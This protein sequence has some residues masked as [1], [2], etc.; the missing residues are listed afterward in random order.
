MK[1]LLIYIF[2]LI[3]LNVFSQGE[4][5]AVTIAEDYPL[6][7]NCTEKVEEFINKRIRN[8]SLPPSDT[9][10][11]VNYHL[12]ALGTVE[13]VSVYG[14]DNQEFVSIITEATKNLT[15]W[16]PAQTRNQP[17]RVSLQYKII[18]VLNSGILSIRAKYLHSANYD[19]FILERNSRYW[20]KYFE[21]NSNHIIS[22]LEIA[23]VQGYIFSKLNKNDHR[24]LTKSPNFRTGTIRIPT[25]REKTTWSIFVPKLKIYD[26]GA[27]QNIRNL[28]IK[29]I[30]RDNDVLLIVIK[31][32]NYR[33]EISINEFNFT[34]Q[35]KLNFDFQEYSFHELNK[36][37]ERFIDR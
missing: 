10:I 34:G 27:S 9:S 16:I 7:L 31:E 24:R 32:K 15:D 36:E 18:P 6:C 14:T 4:H 35:R 26:S 21:E 37:I 3:S 12:T 22:H 19:L 1:R 11:T 33:V 30:P 29:D 17:V 25:N 20:E 8:L 2:L 5:Q 13:N 23:K 28:R